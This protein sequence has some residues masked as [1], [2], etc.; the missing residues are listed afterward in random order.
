MAARPWPSKSFFVSPGSSNARRA[1][2]ARYSAVDFRGSPALL[3]SRSVGVSPMPAIAVCPRM[4]M[5]NFLSVPSTDSSAP[6]RCQAIQHQ[7][8]RGERLGIRGPTAS[9]LFLL[10][11]TGKAGPLLKPA[12][13]LRGLLPQSHET[14]CDLFLHLWP[15]SR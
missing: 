14:S 7:M 6:S 3:P 15:A 10:L 5:K 1:A 4:L 13:H 9:G 11:R 2:H 12:Q 8:V